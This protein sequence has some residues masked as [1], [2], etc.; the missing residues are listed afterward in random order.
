[1]DKQRTIQRE[2][3]LKGV[4]LHTSKKVNL[5]FKPADADTGINFIRVDLP[6]QPV[7]KASVEY[8]LSQSRFPRRTCL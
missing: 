8:L 2:I 4:G 5:T 1:M 6:G 3:S 7:I